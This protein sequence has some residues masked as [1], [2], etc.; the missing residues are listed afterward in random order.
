M[1]VTVRKQ[2]NISTHNTVRRSISSSLLQK[3]FPVHQCCTLLLL[4]LLSS[5]ATA[6]ECPANQYFDQA[7]GK[8][9]SRCKEG[10]G[11]VQQ[12]TNSSTSE[13]VCRACPENTFSEATLSG[14][15]CRSCTICSPAR[16]TVSSCTAT[17]N[18]KCGTCSAGWFLYVSVHTSSCLKCSPCPPNVAVIHW[19]ECAEAGLPRDNQCSPGKGL[20]AACLLRPSLL[21]ISQV[22]TTTHSALSYLLTG[23][24]LYPRL[25]WRA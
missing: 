10:E 22:S 16:I 2:Q 5:T 12:C 23:E 1:T 6:E 4:L 15:V 8:C 25:T 17:Q 14:R 11:I 21:C 18:S 3:R 9:C 19:Q 20:V 24:G 7:A 13:T